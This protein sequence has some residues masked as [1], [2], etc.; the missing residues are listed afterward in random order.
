MRFIT[1]GEGCHE[2]HCEGDDQTVLSGS[3]VWG[4]LE[5]PDANVEMWEEKRSFSEGREV[6]K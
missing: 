3:F 6:R 4:C 1:R 5:G 2:G